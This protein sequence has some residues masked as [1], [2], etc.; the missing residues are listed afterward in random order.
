MTL[1]KLSKT[2]VLGFA[3][4]C[5]AMLFAANKGS[6]QIVNPVTINGQQLKSG[7][8]AVQWDGN[9]P[10]VHVQIMR[11]KKVVATSD[12]KMINVDQVP[13]RDSAILTTNPDGSKSLT[14]IRF[15]GKKY[16]LSLQATGTSGGAGGAAGAAR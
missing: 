2:L 4:L 15:G 7:Q 9:G 12:A 3:V 5:S 13:A 11:N 14:E 1:Q 6:L 10:D 16:A 8:Y